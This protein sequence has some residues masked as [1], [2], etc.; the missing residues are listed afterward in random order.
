MVFNGEND[1]LPITENDQNS[2]DRAI[3]TGL[4]DDRIKYP[5]SNSI[6]TKQVDQIKYRGLV[7]IFF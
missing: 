4:V 3:S 2:D 1:G 6:T 7:P 5:K